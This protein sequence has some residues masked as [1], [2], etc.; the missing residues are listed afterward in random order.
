MRIKICIPGIPEENN[1]ESEG[2]S[3]N[4]A[5]KPKTALP[6]LEHAALNG[7]SLIS[8]SQP[9]PEESNA[10]SQPK[11][12]VKIATKTQDKYKKS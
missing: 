8:R 2:F 10:L 3:A 6:S 12:E 9:Y 5:A 4:S 7:T 1:E 11:S